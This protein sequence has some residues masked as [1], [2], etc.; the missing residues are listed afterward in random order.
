[1]YV[2]SWSPDEFGSVQGLI[3][4]LSIHDRRAREADCLTKCN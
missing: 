3:P 2:F 1:M 4:L